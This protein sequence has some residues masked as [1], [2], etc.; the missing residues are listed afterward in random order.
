MVELHGSGK[1]KEYRMA[2]R[3]L[4]HFSV[5]ETA[6]EEILHP[7]GCDGVRPCAGCVGDW[8]KW[9]KNFVDMVIFLFKMIKSGY[10]YNDI[11]TRR[12]NKI[13]EFTQLGLS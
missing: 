8:V 9:L 2:Y 4:L 1:R 6:V 11:N 7:A 5:I 13:D 3:L 12:K 10:Y